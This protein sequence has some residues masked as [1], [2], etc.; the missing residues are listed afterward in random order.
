[1]AAD[2][3]RLSPP[4][5]PWKT[6]ENFME[7]LKGQVLPTHVDRSVLPKTMA[8]TLQRQLVSALRYLQL[9]DSG[10][11]VTDSMR[12]LHR[13]WATEE[14]A[15]VLSDVVFDAYREITN[16]LDLDSGTAAQLF[17]RF[18]AAGGVDGQVRQ[19]SVRF[20]LSAMQAANV[21][22]SP[23]FATRGAGAD[24]TAKRAAPKREGAN[25][26]GNGSAPTPARKKAAK[27]SVHDDR[28]RHPAREGMIDFDI[29]LGPG[30]SQS[31]HIQFPQ[32]LTEADRA[33]IDAVLRAYIARQGSQN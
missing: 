21:T 12:K 10:N 26:G 32:N 20:F 16:G 33:M 29:P 28:T 7:R 31:V 27:A 17:E 25:G 5:I 24:R 15:E 14:R 23:H 30:P 9:I 22:L 18:K 8:G 4:Y 1:M 2:P 13:A 11:A 3:E 6:F 19:K